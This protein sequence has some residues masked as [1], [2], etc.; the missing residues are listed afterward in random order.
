[1]T[2]KL[3]RAT[4]K[5]QMNQA[6][7]QKSVKDNEV[8]KSCKQDETECVEKLAREAESACGKGDIKTLYNITRQFSG[9][10]TTTN[11]SDKN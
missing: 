11:T 10:T 7:E 9:R 4:T 5:H 1:M 8:N 6:Q 3:L 2:E